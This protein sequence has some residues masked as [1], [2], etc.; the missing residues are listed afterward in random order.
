M[1][2]AVDAFVL[3]NLNP[4]KK[5][6][7]TKQI[8]DMLGYSETEKMIRILEADEYITVQKGQPP[9]KGDSLFAGN[10]THVKSSNIS[11]FYTE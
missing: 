1:R 7:P 8:T 9:F 4:R 3:L 5:N 6:I 11:H 10:I 2:I